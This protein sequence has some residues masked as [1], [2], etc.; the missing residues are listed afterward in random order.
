MTLAKHY[1]RGA[2]ISGPFK[3]D[4]TKPNLVCFLPGETTDFSTRKVGKREGARV[5]VST[6]QG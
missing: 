1:R 5:R 2:Y 3:T 6:T 4:F